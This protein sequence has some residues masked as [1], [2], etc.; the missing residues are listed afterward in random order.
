[1]GIVYVLHPK[2][3]RY[4]EDLRNIHV[5][6]HAHTHMQAQEQRQNT[7]EHNNRYVHTSCDRRRDQSNEG[8]IYIGLLHWTPSV[9][10]PL[11]YESKK[12]L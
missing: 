11:E 1:M 7:N 10:E 6:T 5:Y 3:F 12:I 4:G 9:I 8:T 2:R